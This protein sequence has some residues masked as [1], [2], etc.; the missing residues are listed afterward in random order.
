MYIYNNINNI[1]ISYNLCTCSAV[2]CFLLI[3]VCLK[4]NLVLNNSY[5][6]LT[7]TKF[8]GSLAITVQDVRWRGST[9]PLPNISL[10]IT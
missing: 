10:M 4:Q 3:I 1:I 9:V 5:L 7:S 6:A 2:L 8:A